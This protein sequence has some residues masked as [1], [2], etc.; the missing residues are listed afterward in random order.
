MSRSLRIDR[1]GTHR[2]WHTATRSGSLAGAAMPSHRL[3]TRCASR[4]PG[5][6]SMT[7]DRHGSLASRRS[8]RIARSLRLAGADRTAHNSRAGSLASRPR[9][10]VSRSLRIDRRGT[11]R[12]WRTAARSGSLAGA[13][14]PS[15][16]L[17]TR[18][19]SLGPGTPSMTVARHG[20]LAS[21]R[22][23]RIA[24]SL[25]LAGADRTAHHSRAGSL[26]SRPHLRVSR[27]LR[28]ERRGTH[29]AWHTAA[30]SGSLAG[31]AMPSHRLRTRCASRGPGTPSMTADRHGSLASRRPLRVARSLRLASADRTAHHQR[32]RCRDAGSITVLRTDNPEPTSA[33]LTGRRAGG[34]GM[35]FQSGDKPMS[36]TFS[37]AVQQRAVAKPAIITARQLAAF[38]AFA[39]ERGELIEDDDDDP[40][41]SASFEARVCPWSL[42][43][44]CALFDHDE[45]VIAVVEEAQ[46][47]GLTIRFWRDDATRSIRMC[48]GSSPDG[49]AEIDL[50]NQNGYAVLEAMGLG[51][52]ACGDIPL[53]DLRARL[54]KPDIRKAMTD[55]G[56]HSYLDRLDRIAATS[57]VADDVRMVWG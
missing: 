5:T 48:V 21:R 23:L 56:L 41:V 8:L 43:S 38:R 17:R 12:A 26:A 28:I 30:R 33:T 45:A 6:A 35:R 52:E 49:A 34:S 9:L 44:I 50:S 25:R 39:R 37:L 55:N 1:R 24:R 46:F 29:R 22:S 20:S 57:T 10:R 54:G 36:I 27:S 19:A 42:A 14:M 3:R 47:R 51:T 32:T 4:G 15:H 53:D 31:A 40:L 13:A 16:R 2:A 7:A 11:H 18:C